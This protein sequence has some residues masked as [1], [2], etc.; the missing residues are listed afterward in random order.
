MNNSK[1]IECDEPVDIESVNRTTESGTG[2]TLE[3]KLLQLAD[4]GLPYEPVPAVKE[5]ADLDEQE[6]AGRRREL[7]DFFLFG[8][9]RDGP[10]TSTAIISVVPALLYQY[11]DLKNIRHDYPFCLEGSESATAVRCLSNIIDD[12]AENVNDESESGKRLKHHIHSIEPEIRELA[13]QNRT[14]GLLGLW[15]RAAKNLRAKSQLSKEKTDLLRDNLAVTRRSLTD[16]EM[17]SCGTHTAQQLLAGLARI[18]WR[19][20]SGSTREELDSVLQQLTD[21]LSIDFNSS[22]EGQKPEHLRQATA[23]DDEIDFDAMSSILKAS[24]LDHQLPDGRKNRIQASLDILQNAKPLFAGDPANPDTRQASPF[25]IDNLFASTAAAIQAYDT[26]MELIVDFFKAMAIARLEIENRYQEDVHDDYFERFDVKY[27]DQHELT[28]YPPVL[29][30]IRCSEIVEEDLNTLMTLLTSR[31]PVKLLLQVDDLFTRE[32]TSER[33]DITINWPA[34]LAGM[35]MA[36]TNAY[37]MQAPVSQLQALQKGFLDGLSFHGPALFSVYVGKEEYS[38]GLP[39][40]FDAGAAMEARVFPLFSFDPGKGR[41]LIERLD[42]LGNSQSDQDWSSDTFSYRNAEDDEATLELQ[43]TPAD[44]LLNNRLFVD[45][46]W[47]LEQDYRHDGLIPLQVYLK[48]QTEESENKIPYILAVDEDACI[49]RVVVTRNIVELVRGCSDSWHQLQE[50]G[51][52]R[53]SFAIKQLEEET[54]RLE[55]E[56]VTEVAAIEEEYRLQMERDVGKLTE[57]IVQ[58]IAHQLLVRGEAPVIA[59]DQPPPTAAPQAAAAP[60]EAAAAA[61]APEPAAQAEDEEEDE[62]IVAFDAPYIDTPLC[63]SCD[64]CTSLNPRLFAYD[65]NKQAI[66]K[67][68]DAGPFKDLVIAAEICPVKIIHPGKPRSP[69]EPGL[70]DLIKRATPFN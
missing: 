27:L 42:V 6:Q 54:I 63:T 46:F 44:F 51:G 61:A 29:M 56:K 9:R 26:R 49:H 36:T 34:R 39:A 45:Q 38:S 37:V 11:R 7:F 15:D 19:E 55:A 48:L 22:E 20:R 59:F 58:R 13:Y 8:N 68:P 28:F 69:D 57:Q 40:Y 62:V 1:S 32:M 70:D 24:H 65:D 33:S 2:E 35:A 47:R 14:A 23:T 21:L 67:D 43:F 41:T 17:I 60:A 66:I 31:L 64:D 5:T 30:N 4:G 10:Q 52:I 25:E 16:S 3:D 50:F 18:H 12:L 53:N